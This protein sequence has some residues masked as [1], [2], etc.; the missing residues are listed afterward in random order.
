MSKELLNHPHEPVFAFAIRVGCEKEKKQ[1]HQMPSSGAKVRAPRRV[2]I[3]VDPILTV[4]FKFHI[5]A[6]EDDS[7]Y[8]ILVLEED[9]RRAMCCTWHNM[10][11]W[12]YSWNSSAYGKP[13]HPN[14]D[15]CFL[16][17]TTIL[18]FFSGLFFCGLFPLLC[19]MVMLSRLAMSLDVYIELSTNHD[20]NALVRVSQ[21]STVF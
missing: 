19:L 10:S 12:R 20:E 1:G 4:S 15:S 17:E 6:Q 21:S 13:V 16:L 18:P 2:G 14:P 3:V 11:K 8:S 5:G 7:V 9:L